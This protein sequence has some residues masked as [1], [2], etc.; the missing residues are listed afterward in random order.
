MLGDK[1]LYQGRQVEIF[2]TVKDGHTNAFIRDGSRKF[3]VNLRLLSPIPE[4]AHF[5]TRN[6]I[7]RG[8]MI[9]K[10]IR[11]QYVQHKVKT[12][13]GKSYAIDNNDDLASELRG[14]G[15]E[16]VYKLAVERLAEQGEEVTVEQLQERYGNLNPG[17]Q[18]MNLGNRIRGAETKAKTRAKRDEEKAKRAEEKAKRDEER[19]EAKAKREAEVAEA[20]EKREQELAEKK[21]QKEA[22]AEAKAEADAEAKAKKAEAKK[23]PVEAVVPPPAKK[24][25]KKAHHKAA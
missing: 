12:G 3:R 11:A 24:N 6:R 1:M 17:M 13:S 2:E 19:A 7:G 20:K 10:E 16:D 14:M 25:G 15:L 23:A 21:A 18:R 8:N 9:P 22:E 4:G 5:T